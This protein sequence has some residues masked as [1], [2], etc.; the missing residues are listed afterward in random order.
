MT[1]I[2]YFL[3]ALELKLQHRRCKQMS[4]SGSSKFDITF[5]L[6]NS[7]SE[8]RCCFIGRDNFSSEIFEIWCRLNKCKILFRSKLLRSLFRKCIRFANDHSIWRSIRCLLQHHYESETINQNQCNWISSNPV[9][10]ACAGLMSASV[11]LSVERQLWHWERVCRPGSIL[12]RTEVIFLRQLHARRHGVEVKMVC[13]MF[14]YSLR[15][16]IYVSGDIQ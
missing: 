6:N 16:D 3:F 5:F 9:S 12:G 15:S 2:W 14:Q 10:N 8:P 7:E 4:R 1:R 13:V 11:A